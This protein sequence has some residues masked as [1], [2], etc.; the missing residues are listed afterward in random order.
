MKKLIVVLCAVWCALLCCG[1]GGR[2]DSDQSFS[3]DAVAYEAAV[4]QEQL[5]ECVIGEKAQGQWYFLRGTG[6][7]ENELSRCID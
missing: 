3:K 5:A 6:V 2:L 7:D 1:C 4:F